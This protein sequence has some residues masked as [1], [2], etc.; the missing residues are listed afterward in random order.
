M[1]TIKLTITKGI[2]VMTKPQNNHIRNIIESP[3]IGGFPQPISPPNVVQTYLPLIID[4]KPV[5][6][7]ANKEERINDKNIPIQTDLPT[8]DF[9]LHHLLKLTIG[10]KSNKRTI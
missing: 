7:N 10:I 1:P 4:S 3:I 2:K 8:I 9:L 5:G 6:K